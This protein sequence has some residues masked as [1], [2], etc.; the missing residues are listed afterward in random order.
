M[1]ST[2]QPIDTQNSRNAFIDL[3]RRVR[4]DRYGGIQPLDDALGKGIRLILA[5]RVSQ[6]RVETES[7]RVLQLAANRL[8]AAEFDPDSVPRMIVSLIHQCSA[9]Q[10]PAKAPVREIVRREQDAVA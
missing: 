4:E 7:H 6:E 8:R 2:H 5:H 10:L 9:E 3:T 1:A